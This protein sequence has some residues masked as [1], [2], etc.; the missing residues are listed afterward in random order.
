MLPKT[1]YTHWKI[2]ALVILLVIVGRAVINIYGRYQDS[3]AGLALAE[4]ELAAM[5]NKEMA[6]EKT[7][8]KL[9]T[10]Q[11]IEEAIRQ[12]YQVA[13]DHEQLIVIVN[14]EQKKPTDATTKTTGWWQTLVKFFGRD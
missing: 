3:R 5:E 2:A 4:K 7:T 10:E 11:G 8:T 13:K 6:L 14:D 9:K 12:K 1:F